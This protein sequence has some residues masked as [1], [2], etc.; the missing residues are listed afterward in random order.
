MHQVELDEG[1]L[2]APLD[3]YDVLLV[4]GGPMD[5]WE[6]QNAT[7]VAEMLPMLESA[8]HTL[9]RNFLAIAEGVILQQIAA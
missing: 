4:M 2:I 9:F 6:E 7:E 8:A 5:V 1:D 3:D